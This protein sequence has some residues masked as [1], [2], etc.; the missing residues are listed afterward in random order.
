VRGEEYVSWLDTG[1]IAGGISL[2]GRRL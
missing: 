1:C 2:K